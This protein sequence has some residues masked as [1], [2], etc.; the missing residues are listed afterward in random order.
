MSLTYLLGT[1]QDKITIDI[2]AA[3]K[4]A[5]KIIATLRLLFMSAAN[6]FPT[7]NKIGLQIQPNKIHSKS[8]YNFINYIVS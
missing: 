1:Y 4:Q 7:K 8:W 6:S 2:A 3:N 5:V